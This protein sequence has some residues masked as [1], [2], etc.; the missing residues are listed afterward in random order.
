MH[1]RVE[2]AASSAPSLPNCQGAGT[3]KYFNFVSYL[4]PV[5]L[6]AWKPC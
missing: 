3:F 6:L 1:S 2:G 4:L 5:N